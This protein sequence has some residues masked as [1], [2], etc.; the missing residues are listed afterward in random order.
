M[1][2][3]AIDAVIRTTYD[4]LVS[5]LFVTTDNAWPMPKKIW[6]KGPRTKQ[7]LISEWLCGLGKC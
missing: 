2:I 1:Q 6:P 5:N 3:V 4:K 7:C